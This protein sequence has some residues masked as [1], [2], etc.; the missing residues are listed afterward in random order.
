MF[1]C[2]YYKYSN[3]PTILKLHDL[4]LNFKICTTIFF[5]HAFISGEKTKYTTD[6]SEVTSDIT[7]PVV[8]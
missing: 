1:M 2:V 6:K 5:K 3:A 4:Y 8:N 7:Q